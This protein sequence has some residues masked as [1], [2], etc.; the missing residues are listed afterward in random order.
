[1]E[2]DL[3]AV[4]TAGVALSAAVASVFKGRAESRHLAVTSA[5]EA[6]DMLKDVHDKRVDQLGVE[7]AIQRR[8]RHEL[9]EE[10]G[11]M[12]H[13]IEKLEQWI[14]EDGSDETKAKF[15]VRWED[16]P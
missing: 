9:E 1:M 6:L 2:L 3:V 12:E 8:R 15:A 7:L 5:H 14:V 10:V 4:I 11:A 16:V 13:R